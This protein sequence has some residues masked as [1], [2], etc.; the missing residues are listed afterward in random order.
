[1]KRLHPAWVS[2]F[3]LIEL[4]VALTIFALMSAMA[5][6]GLNAVLETREQVLQDNRKWRELAVFFSMLQ[7]DLHASV[8]RTVRDAYDIRAPAF[9]GKT[10]ALNDNDAQLVFTRMGLPGQA[11]ALADLQRYGYRLRE[12]KVELLVWPAVDL[13]PRSRPAVNPVLDKVTGFDLRYLDPAGTW[14][15]SWP[16]LGQEYPL[17]RAVEIKLTLQSGEQ[18]TRI[19]AL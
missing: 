9:I 6:R 19:F 3:T 11:G 17:P 18:I 2:G 10:Q 13:A 15:A 4:L 7:R 5:Y 1:M 12:H 8:N 14:Q 16:V